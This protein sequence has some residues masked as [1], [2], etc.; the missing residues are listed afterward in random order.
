MF[1]SRRMDLHPVQ[2]YLYRVIAL[3]QMQAQN[4][5]DVELLERAGLNVITIR[6]TTVM[7]T[8]IPIV[9]IYAIFQKHFI[10]GVMIGAIKG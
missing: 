3:S 10:K 9:F 6:A 4:P 8:T 5:T 2:T 7:V 1:T